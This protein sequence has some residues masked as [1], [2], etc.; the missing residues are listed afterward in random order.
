MTHEL[1]LSLTLGYDGTDFHGWA[2]QPG[3]LTV[4]GALEEALGMILR[5]PVRVV[6]AGR[7]D[8]GVHARRQ[9]V[10][11]DLTDDEAAAVI[12]RS[13]LSLEEALL[14]RIDGTLARVLGPKRGAVVVYEVRRVP[15]DFD[16]RFSA[17]DRSYVYRIC[18]ARGEWDPLTR[19]MAWWV[20]QPLDAALMAQAAG[21]LVG[22]R[23]FAGFCKPREGATTIRGLH[24][25][26]VLRAESG[27]LEV[28]LRA[29]A[30]CHHMVRNI[31]AALVEVGKGAQTPDEVGRR[32]EGRDVR[33]R[34]AMA[35]PHGLTLDG[36]SYPPPEELA[37]R[38][39][40][41][42]ALREAEPP[43]EEQVNTSFP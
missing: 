43:G 12:S 26:R 3:L 4:Q 5:R 30:F 16:A 19:R 10:H 17:L 29:D 6:V 33:R 11:L 38:A 15:R 39:A 13:S 22:V 24:S 7:T 9:V 32:L 37:A 27:M 8:T 14:R 31:V 18:D 28:R 23:D 20:P 40:V 25:V 34:P 35:P 42:R 36:V 1:R 2:V 21:L 41:T